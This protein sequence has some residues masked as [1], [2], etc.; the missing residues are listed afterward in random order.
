MMSSIPSRLPSLYTTDGPQTTDGYDSDKLVLDVEELAR[1]KFA[2]RAAQHDQDGSFPRENFD[3]LRHAGLLGLCI[4]REYGGIGADFST[5][6]RVSAAIA[7]HCAAT[8]FTFNMHSCNLM[9]I[10]MLADQI[11]MQTS[12]RRLLDTLRGRRYR[13]VIEDGASL[14][15]LSLKVAPAFPLAQRT[16]RPPHRYPAVAVSRDARYLLRW[17]VRLIT[18]APHVRKTGKRIPREHF[19]CQLQQ[20]VKASR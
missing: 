6:A 3:D 12:E 2:P 13:R 9:W 18:M 19:T 14:P 7:H 4:P 11:P 1:S 8:A 10:G 20:V 5:Y 15:S 17:P 16:T